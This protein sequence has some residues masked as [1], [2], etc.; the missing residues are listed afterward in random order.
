MARCRRRGIE[1]LSNLQGVEAILVQETWLKE[2]HS[3]YFSGRT[4]IRDDSGVGTAIIIDNRTRFN[5]VRIGGLNHIN[6]TAIE[7]SLNKGEKR[8]LASVYVPCSI[9]KGELENDLEAI[10]QTATK[11]S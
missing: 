6:Y 2:R 7:I 11:S 5:R 1:S 9:K 4:V 3:L 8:L 10:L